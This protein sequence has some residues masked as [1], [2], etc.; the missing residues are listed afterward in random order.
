M[1]ESKEAIRERLLKIIDI[2]KVEYGEDVRTALRH[3]DAFQ[4]LISAIL[5]AQTTDVQVNKVTPVLFERYKSPYELSEAEP[6]EVEEIIRSIG[7]YKKKARTIIECAKMI[8]KEYG[9]E[10]PNDFEKLIRLPGVGR[11]TANVVLGNYFGM[12][13]VVVDTHVKR[14]ANRLGISDKT[15]PDKI[16]RDIQ[17]VLPMEYWSYFTSALIKHGRKYCKA[18]KPKCNECPIKELC[19]T[20]SEQRSNTNEA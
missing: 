14:L 8:V 15:Q 18:L 16:E 13:S 17:D 20:Y 6:Y 19:P 3:R 9:G 5:S 12:P 4:L 11:K 7:F 2:F 1:R 10:V